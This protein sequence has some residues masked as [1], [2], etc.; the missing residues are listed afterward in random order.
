MEPDR[1]EDLRAAIALDRR[2]PHLGHRL[3]DPLDRRLE[4]V[5]DGGFVVE[6]G[7]H[8]LPDHVV[9]GL[10]SQIRVDGT[11]PVADEKRKVVDF[12]GLAGFE[13]QAHFRAGPLADQVVVQ[14]RDGQQSG[15]GDMFAVHTAI[16]EDEDIFS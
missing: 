8:P 16:A 9:E 5:F 10:E 4:E 11:G 12:A 13:H 1:L 14:T 2:D 7:K 6:P 15:N 3:D